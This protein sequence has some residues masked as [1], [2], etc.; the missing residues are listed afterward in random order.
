MLKKLLKY[1]FKSVAKLL[2]PILLGIIGLALINAILLSISKHYIFSD[3]VAM[4]TIYAIIALISSFVMLISIFVLYASI[5]ILI[6]LILQRYYTNFFKD[7]GYLTFT[8]PVEIKDHFNAKII[9]GLAWMFMGGITIS[10]AVF[11][12]ALFASAPDGYIINTHIFDYIY[13]Y[14]LRPI[15]EGVSTTDLI[16]YIVEI[17]VAIFIV[18]LGQLLLYY[19]AVTI[20]CIISKKHKVLASIGVYFGINTGMG[21]LTSILLIIIT[22]IFAI[23]E[24]GYDDSLY[25]NNFLQ[26]YMLALIIMYSIAAIVAYINCRSML[27]KKLNLE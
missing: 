4:P 15:I 9:S 1:E 2:V 21:I 24:N 12:V 27:T 22:T 11:I 7:E 25:A 20:G 26:I 18:A 23:S 17:I 16:I 19:L 3:N 8:L 10:I 5:F 6:I 14:F 13:I